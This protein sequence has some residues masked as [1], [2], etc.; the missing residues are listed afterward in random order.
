MSTDEDVNEEILVP[1]IDVV[2]QLYILVKEYN[3]LTPEIEE[4][5][6]ETVLKYQKSS[7]CI[8]LISDSDYGQYSIF[9]LFCESVPLIVSRLNC[10][11]SRKC[12]TLNDILIPLLSLQ[13]TTFYILNSDVFK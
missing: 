13:F 12:V 9:S 5:V 6:K 3:M 1:I 2:Q 8:Y 10:M 7:Y 11:I 4:L